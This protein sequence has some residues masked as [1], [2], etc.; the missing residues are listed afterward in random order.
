MNSSKD[1][2]TKSERSHLTRI[3]S[4]HKFSERLQLIAISLIRVGDGAEFYAVTVL[5]KSVI[6][7]LNST[8]LQKTVLSFSMYAALSLLTIIFLPIASFIQKRVTIMLSLYVSVI[9]T[10]ISV[11]MPTYGTI[12]A[13]R[14]AAG[15]VVA[16]HSSI[17]H[18]RVTANNLD[19]DD[20]VLGI[21]VV[22]KGLFHVG[23]IWCGLY[24]LHLFGVF[25]MEMAITTYF[26][27]VLLTITSFV[28]YILVPIG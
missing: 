15:I 28:S 9:A 26:D 5:L 3:E 4:R 14:I 8:Q 6:C 22:D 1:K 18:S 21:I 11:A 12:L 24:R 25:S 10:G 17:P 19:R 16:L 20:N 2:P 7:E 23:G 27:T 13:C